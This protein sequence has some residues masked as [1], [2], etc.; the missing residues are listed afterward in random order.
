VQSVVS[1]GLKYFNHFLT[2]TFSRPLKGGG[3]AL[4][5]DAGLGLPVC[6]NPPQAKPRS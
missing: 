1:A 6:R 3:F 5:L 2:Q 4:G